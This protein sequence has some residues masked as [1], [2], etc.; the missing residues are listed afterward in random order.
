LWSRLPSQMPG[1][2]ERPKSGMSRPSA[3]AHP[4][5]AQ[6]GQH[7]QLSRPRPRN[8]EM[9]AWTGKLG[10]PEIGRGGRGRKEF[11]RRVRRKVKAKSRGEAGDSGTGEGRRR[12]RSPYGVRRPKAGAA[13]G[14][15]QSAETEGASARG[16]AGSPSARDGPASSK[17]WRWGLEPTR[18]GPPGHRLW[19]LAGCE[20]RSEGAR[21]PPSPSPRVN[22][23]APLANS[24]AS[25]DKK[26]L[27]Q[28][29]TRYS[30]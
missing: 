28:G 1:G 27:P 2:F 11:I 13:G 14:S 7:P 6:R 9:R 17:S 12:A 22:E 18:R 4:V 16:G 23:R 8:D 26:P 21:L 29:L 10:S 20:I 25:S 24:P 5:S 30:I 3:L 15:S 19:G